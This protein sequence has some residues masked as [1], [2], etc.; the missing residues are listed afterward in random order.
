MTRF[1]AWLFAIGWLAGPVLAGPLSL[2][3]L[4]DDESIY[5]LPEP[6][7]PNEGVNQGGVH[8]DVAVRYMSDYIYRGIDNSE[9]GGHEDAPNLQF[10]GQLSFDL[11]KAP[12]PFVGAFINIYDS[13]PI[14]RF[15]EIRPFFGLEWTIR[16]LIMTGGHVTYILPERE[17]LNSSEIYGKIEIDDSYFLHTEH[18][19]FGPYVYAAY[20]YDLNNGW[21]MEAGLRHVHPID[22][23]GLT[24]SLFADIAYVIAQQH[25]VFPG[26][27]DTGFQ[28][29]EVGAATSYSLNT[30]F[31]LPKRYG[32][33]SLEGYLNYTDGLTHGLRADTQLWGGVGIKFHY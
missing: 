2:S 19:I 14:S 16:P 28:H 7:K 18:A 31:N 32:E 11:G 33:F 8:V 1:G 20:D 29:W 12:H 6:P 9:V 21:Y 5:A 4:P 22:D 23:T 25:F 10:D 17:N 26:E 24:V 3:M 27:R 13:D 30:L 15:Q